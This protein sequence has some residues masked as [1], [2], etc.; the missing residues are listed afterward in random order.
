MTAEEAV[1][2]AENHAENQL[3]DK[4]ARIVVYCDGGECQASRALA[5][6]LRRQGYGKVTLYEGGKQDWLEAGY[7]SVGAV[8]PTPER[9]K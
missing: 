2:H 1:H 4:S 7:T 6:E 5:E 9:R 3:P 8:M